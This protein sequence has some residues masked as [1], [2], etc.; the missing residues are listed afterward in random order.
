MRVVESNTPAQ[1]SGF[2]CFFGLFLF[3]ICG[4]RSFFEL[5]CHLG[6]DPGNRSPLPPSSLLG[7]GQV[8]RFI[9][10]RKYVVLHQSFV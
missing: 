9:N 10:E 8:N 7:A 1:V 3:P 6:T 5:C 2:Y 4:S